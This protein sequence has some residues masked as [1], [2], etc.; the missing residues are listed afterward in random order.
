M[1]HSHSNT[2]ALSITLALEP[3]PGRMYMSA[4]TGKGHY[5]LEVFPKKLARQIRFTAMHLQSNI[6]LEN[7]TDV[8]GYTRIPE[9]K[10]KRSGQGRE[11]RTCLRRN[12]RSELALGVEAH[13]R[14]AAANM[15]LV[16]KVLNK[17]VRKV[18]AWN[19]LTNEDVGDCA[20]TGLLGEVSLDSV[21]L[22]HFVEPVEGGYDENRLKE[23]SK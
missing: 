4:R 3:T 18:G 20:L 9:V 15:L 8:T 13:D 14:V 23:A 1:F 7:I 22:F 19:R 5:D 17:P 11:S 10:H 12:E 2:N 6:R 21:T 16:C